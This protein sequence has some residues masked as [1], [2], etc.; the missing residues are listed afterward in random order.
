MSAAANTPDYP[1]SAIALDATIEDQYAYLD[2][3][4]GGTLPQSATLNAQRAAVHDENTLLRYAE[5]RMISL[6]DHHAITCSSFNDSWAVV[7]TYA[8]LWVV[9]HD[10]RYVIDAV[11]EGSPAALAGIQPG[12]AL[13]A[14][15]G[16]ETSSAVSAFWRDLGLA[17][18]PARADFAARMLAAGRR[19][20]SR[21]LSIAD[22]A[23][24]VR[25][26]T[27]PSLY[28]VI[29]EQRPPLTSFTNQARTVIR[30]N[31]SLGDDKTIA[32]FDSAMQLIPLNHEVIL[33]HRN[34]PSGGNTTVA[35][36]VLGWFTNEPHG[37]QVHNRPIEERETGIARQW[38]EQVL[39]RNGKYRRG[40][41]TI[42]VGRWTGSMGEGLAVGFA[43]M[44]AEVRGGPMAQLNG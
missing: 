6:A 14:I 31:N 23:G 32:A 10:G 11:R 27:L 20:R 36:A 43:S 39:P 3:L 17:I 35:R 19:D 7:P 5:N 2:K 8:D 25:Q 29:S 22:A 9:S 38:I 13:M 21:W 26:L 30:F 41:P 4:P 42:W 12:N 33:D 16:V 44:R 18:N 37:Y 1:A 28:S 15:D 34:T 40:L 24:R